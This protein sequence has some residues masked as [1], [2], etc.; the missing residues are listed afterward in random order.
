MIGPVRVHAICNAYRKTSV[1]AGRWF[2]Y[3][4]GSGGRWK[5]QHQLA[6]N[7]LP[8]ISVEEVM[9]MKAC[10]SFACT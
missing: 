2:F 4:V 8:T 9:T 5:V 7:P 3:R 10:G 6:R 1:R